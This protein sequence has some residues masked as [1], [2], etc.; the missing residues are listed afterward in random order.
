MSFLKSLFGRNPSDQIADTLIAVAR[1]CNDPEAFDASAYEASKNLGA[2]AVSGLKVLMSDPPIQP[3]DTIEEFPG[4]LDWD[5]ACHAAGI[6]IF[7]Y[8]KD[9]ALPA[10][11]ELLRDKDEDLQCQATR[12]LIR[13]YVEDIQTSRIVRA[14]KEVFP[15]WNYGVQVYTAGG[16]A[17][18]AGKEPDLLNL[19]E[20]TA[21]EWAAN[22]PVDA[23][24]IIE[25]LANAEPQHAQVF[26][27]LLRD[28]MRNYGRGLRD[29]R[30]DGHDTT[31][32]IDGEEYT[33]LASG[34]PRHPNIID[35]HAIRA[36]IC[37]CDMLPGDAEAINHL[38]HWAT[39]YPDTN[40]RQEIQAILKE[41]LP[42]SGA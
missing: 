10:L 30:L 1:R 22:D 33:V 39:S 8:L 38:Q 4:F 31:Q 40:K 42:G 11:L 14:L 5:Y 13:F 29:P 41:R 34:R 12:L 28:I 9:L 27:P 18:I 19:L 32:W 16:L 17:V 26:A 7:Y 3:P 6:Q 37:L 20:A 35:F 15:T 21:R 36:A 24:E 23:L 2:R 25:P